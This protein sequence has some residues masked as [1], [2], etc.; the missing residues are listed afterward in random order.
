MVSLHSKISGKNT[1]DVAEVNGKAVFYVSLV[2][3]PLQVLSFI[4][5][6]LFRTS[7]LSR[8]YLC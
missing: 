7:A 2:D 4:V 6:L 1:I 8:F 3:L 5:L